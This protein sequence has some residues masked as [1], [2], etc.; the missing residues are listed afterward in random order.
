MR[1]KALKVKKG[2]KGFDDLFNHCFPSGNY[3]NFAAA[4][5]ADARP[6]PGQRY[7]APRRRGA[8]VRIIGC[9]FM[10]L[11]SSLAASITLAAVPINPRNATTFPVL[12]VGAD[13]WSRYRFNRLVTYGFAR[14][15]TDTANCFYV[16]SLVTDAIGGQNITTIAEM[17]NQRGTAIGRAWETKHHEVN[18]DAMGLEWYSTD[19]S[20]AEAGDTSGDVFIAIDQTANNGDITV[21]WYQCYDIEFAEKVAPS[22]VNMLRHIEARW[23]DLPEDQKKIIKKRVQLL[24]C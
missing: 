11:S 19:S 16:A 8:A 20:S 6:E 21:D 4:A 3:A 17:K 22:V 23:E 18:C 13:T 10:S 15:G 9:D 14:S 7:V 12:S 1:A 2:G 24:L 5:V